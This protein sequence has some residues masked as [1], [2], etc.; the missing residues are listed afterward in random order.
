MSADLDRATTR[1]FLEGL[2]SF[3]ATFEA[4]RDAAREQDALLIT[5]SREHHAHAI[6]F[7]E[8]VTRLQYY[9][10]VVLLTATLEARLAV[11]CRTLCQ[12]HGISYTISGADGSFIDR[13]RD[14]L[15]EVIQAQAPTEMWRWMEDL[16]V[17]RTCI[18]DAA[19]NPS[20]LVPTA[21]RKVESVVRRRSGLALDRDHLLF[22]RS[23]PLP[24][25]AET[26][27]VVRREFCWDAVT[28]VQGLFGYLYQ[29]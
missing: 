3:V 9:S 7:G 16:A 13:V 10:F 18:A 28:A 8:L 27:L 21:R 12:E 23:L 1:N 5:E 15:K 20:L 22:S 26:V 25:H 24:Q 2:R 4:Q 29:D 14:F 17:L 11:Y 6:P 19:G